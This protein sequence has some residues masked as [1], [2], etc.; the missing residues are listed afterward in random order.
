M[1]PSLVLPHLLHQQGAG[2]GWYPGDS[3]GDT[4][5]LE[6]QDSRAVGRKVQPGCPPPKKN[7]TR[8]HHIAEQGQERGRRSC[9]PW[10][11]S[12]GKCTCSGHPQGEQSQQGGC[13]ILGLQT[14]QVVGVQGAAPLVRTSPCT[15]AVHAQHCTLPAP[16][17]CGPLPIAGAPQEQLMHTRC[18]SR[19][20]HCCSLTMLK[21]SGAEAPRHTPALFPLSPTS[22]PAAGQ[23]RRPHAAVS[24]PVLLGSC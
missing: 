9:D 23:W 3:N 1:Q 2:A 13:S 10:G 6:P 11:C 18:Y 22:Q 17:Y 24:S 20:E 14:V 12:A 4:G 8:E 15:K 5:L 16:V 7:C 19:E 21:Q